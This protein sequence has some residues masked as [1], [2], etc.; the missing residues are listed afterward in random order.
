MH[1]VEA[2]LW[3][4]AIFSQMAP[5]GVPA[6]KRLVRPDVDLILRIQTI[7]PSEVRRMYLEEDFTASQI[8]DRLGISKQAVL[9]RVRRTGVRNA[10]AKGRSST[11]YRYRNPPYGLKVLNGTLVPDRREMRVVRQILRLRGNG[12]GWMQI[13]KDLN[14]S[15]ILS[16][17]RKPWRRMGV[18]R[19]HKRWVGKVI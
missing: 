4:Q 10:Q 2:A 7:D 14:A 3:N 9:A 18:K 13:V 11:N 8:A 1:E 5:T 15:G 12:Y 6:R 19:V 17:R 16:R